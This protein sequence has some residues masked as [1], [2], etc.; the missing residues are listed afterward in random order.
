[1]PVTDDGPPMTTDVVDDTGPI[2]GTSTGDVPSSG[3]TAWYLGADPDGNRWT[4]TVVDPTD[5][6][7]VVM[8]MD[9]D[10]LAALSGPMPRGN[11]AGPNW[12]DALPSTDQGRIFANA[13]SVDKVA[14]FETTTFTLEAVL[15]VGAAP[16]HIFNPNQGNEIWTHA[17]T[18][19]EFYVIDQTS[20]SVSDPVVA[21]SHGGHGKLLYAEQLGT[22]YYAT[23]VNDPGVF[24]IDGDTL[25]VGPLIELCGQPCEDDPGTPDDE[26]L[27]TCG[28]THY[29][30][31]DPASGYAIFQCSGDTG[32]NYA[33]VDTSDD[34]VVADL[35]PMAG[36]VA[37]S[38]GWA[39]TLVID[40]DAGVQIWDSGA[41]GHDV[42]T[43]FD[44]V[45]DVPGS[46]NATGTDFRERDDGVWEAWLPENQGTG[47]AVIDLSSYTM[48]E[49]IEIGPLSPAAGSTSAS[50]RGI[51]GGHWFFT[52]N[53]DGIVIVDLDTHEV[54]Q[55]PAPSAPVQRVTFAANG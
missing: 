1:M 12:A 10:D 18:P 51:I 35:V 42:V 37:F 17:D 14:V 55:G 4:V 32:G 24:P 33:F 15:D 5:P 28:G 53:D 19:G 2:D 47:L 36:S 34:T 38:H 16:V 6:A 49:E 39:Y 46:P 48:T 50:R 54:T 11:G 52:Y 20:L 31:F 44:G 22:K 27:L 29:K 8:E 21:S 40:A 7:L 43:A 30:A 26:S 3:G 23:E 25:T 45:V 13:R 9:V 41:D